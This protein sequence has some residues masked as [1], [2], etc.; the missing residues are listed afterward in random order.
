MKSKSSATRSNKTTAVKISDRDGIPFSLLSEARREF[1]T[2]PKEAGEFTIYEYMAKFRISTKTIAMREID[3]LMKNGMVRK[4]RTGR[5]V[6]YRV[7]E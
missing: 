2:T 1:A 7:V 6:Y 3:I 5:N 4:R